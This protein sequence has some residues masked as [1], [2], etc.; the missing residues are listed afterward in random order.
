MA[1]LN[2]YKH[3]L[4]PDDSPYLELDTIPISILKEVRPDG[5][6]LL[7]SRIPLESFPLRLTERLLHWANVSPHKV[8]LGQRNRSR[9]ADDKWKSITYSETHEK[10]RSLGQSLL[11][12]S[13]SK[14]KPI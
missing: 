2:T 13:V 9:S 6:T 1:D 4:A 5:T 3:I 12:R 10:V 11:N 14:E 8:F 7:M